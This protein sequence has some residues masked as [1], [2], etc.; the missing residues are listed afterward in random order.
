MKYPHCSVVILALALV[1]FLPSRMQA[2]QASASAGSTVSGTVICVDSGAPA[3]FAKVLLKSTQPDHTAEDMMRKIQENI[4]KM[5]AKNGQPAEPAKPLSV[6]K[7]KQMAAADENLNRAMEMM[8][9]ATVGLDGKFSFAGVKPGTYYVEAIFPGYIDPLSQFS[10]DDL[11]SIDPA[12]RARL[13][14]IPTITVTGTDSA[15]VDLRLDRGASISG[16]ILYDDGTPA[17]GWIVSVVDP[18]KPDDGLEAMKATMAQALAASGAAGYF[19]TDDLGHYRISGLIAGDYLVSAILVATPTHMNASNPLDKSSDINLVVYS[20][21]TFNRIGARSI[22]TSAGEDH[23]GV[24]ITIPA[25]SLHSIVGHIY[26]KS[27]NHALNMGSVSLSSKDNPTLHR[28]AAIHADGSFQF[29]YLPAGVTYTITADNAEDGKIGPCECNFMGM[30]IPD[31]EVL[32]KYETASAD[33]K[34]GAT[35]DDSVRLAVTQTDWTPPA[36]KPGDSKFTPGDLLN[37]IL[38]ASSDDP[39]N[40]KTAPKP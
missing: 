25:S 38:G 1:L 12:I 16:R 11:A 29:E 30:S 24:D 19:K 17:S 26:A 6:D 4:Q 18:R 34:L 32:H 7:K 28:T 9:A 31:E 10:D 35:D 40:S 23:A 37:G 21:G 15:H 22:T 14:R 5:A 39:G 36:K 13:A 8:K 33:V 20:G 2:Q 27:D 3:R